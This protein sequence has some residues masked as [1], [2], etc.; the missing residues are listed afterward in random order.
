MQPYPWWT[1]YLEPPLLCQIWDYPPDYL[2]RM[3]KDEINMMR[4]EET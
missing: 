3:R 1:L 4:P 2:I